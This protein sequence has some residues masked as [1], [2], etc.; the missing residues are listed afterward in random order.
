MR[1]LFLTISLLCCWS[2]C[3]VAQTKPD[4][5]EMLRQ[6]LSLPAP[7]PRTVAPG[8]NEASPE[9]AEKPSERPKPPADDAPI[10]V[11]R[12][13]WES[14]QGYPP[15]TIRPSATIKERLL[16]VFLDEPEKLVEL[17]PH[18]SPADAEKVKAAFDR[19]PNDEPNRDHRDEIR[20]WLVNHSKYYLNELLAQVNKVEDNPESGSV[21]RESAL[22]NLAEIDWSIA[23]PLLQTLADSSQQ[24]SATLALSML[25]KHAVESGN[26]STE[27]KFRARLQAIASD[28]G[29]PGRARNTAIEALSATK[30]SGR[31]D[32]YLSLLQDE[33][34]ITLHDGYSGFSPLN[35][36]FDADPDKWIPIMTKLVGGPNRTVQRTAASCLVRLVIQSPRRDAILP[37]LRWLSDP[38]W[39]PMGGTER[40]WFMQQM[41][42]L[43]IPESVP[44]LIWIIENEQFNA[45]WAART[46]AHYKDPRAI[47]ALKKA[48]LRS[49]EDD[50]NMILDGL[51]ASG[52]LTEAE[53]IDALEQYVAKLSTPEGRAEVEKNA[54]TSGSALPVPLSIG[55]YFASSRTVSPE[56]ARAVLTH[57]IRL[58]KQNP[59][60]SQALLRITQQWQSREVDLNIINRI[61][62]GTADAETIANALER[63]SKLR[64]S[65]GAELHVLLRAGGVAEAIGSIMLDD[66]ALAQ[67]ILSSGDQPAQIALLASAR[68][69]QT[70]LPVAVV[71]PLMKSRNALLA[72]AAER[73]LLAEDSEEAQTL[74]WQRHPGEAFVTGWREN[75]EFMS[76]NNFDAFEKKEEPLR[77]ELLKDNG[78]VEIFALLNNAMYFDRVLRVYSDRAVYTCYEDPSRYRERV[79]TKAELSAFKQFMQTNKLA[80]LGPQI[81]PCHHD[82]VV[83]ELLLLKKEGGR[84]VFSHRGF[85][86]WLSLLASLDGFG[87]GPGAKYRYALESEIKGLEV[88]YADDQ[89]RVTNVWQ[90]DDEIRVF[91]ERMRTV[92]DERK[93]NDFEP[94]GVD[95]D[96]TRELKRQHEAAYFKSLYAWRSFTAGK[97]TAVVDQPEVYESVD[98]NKF[99]LEI[100]DASLLHRQSSELRVL[101]SNSIIIARNFGGLWKQVAGNKPVRLSTE[102]AY[103]NPVV[104]PDG[105]WVV[106]AKTDSDWSAPNYVIRFNIETGR[107]FRVNLEPADEFGPMVFLPGLGK[108]LLRRMTDETHAEYYL[109]NPNTGETH[110][111]KGE[112]APLV[113]KGDRFLQATGKAEEFW[114]AIPDEAKD[115]T[116]V[117]RYNLKTFAFTPVLTI[118]HI[119]FESMAMWVDEVHNKVYVAYEVQLISIPLQRLV[120]TVVGN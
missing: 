114:A 79:I 69:T 96:T 64:E 16:E 32:W 84:R 41:D 7:T 85:N 27:D 18:L 2:T 73:Y 53:V 101:T 93:L 9:I 118:P 26:A 103:A 104:T 89:L 21:E 105:K 11:L 71:G 57:A 52:G 10:E 62:T 15:S 68:L 50:R 29:N 108:V 60:L 110:T 43:E 30:W 35:E 49:A 4:S 119:N 61:A 45:R 65:L 19:L 97:L 94:E 44:G 76:G 78:P 72:Q 14:Q 113:Q 38:D 77:N 6:L 47:P 24:R 115:Q 102:G 116:Q 95:E 56:I 34:L 117:G 83:S 82:C 66:S 28:R 87:N 99:P 33:T 63:H 80:E 36:I 17:L 13:Y 81:A 55:R 54:I 23:E 109:L 8:T 58:R 70:S 25:Y 98:N 75:L 1:H 111:V 100:E 106:L 51:L 107:E 48:L 67:T 59:E 120:A 3:V 40:A 37:V 22:T 112:F 20:K 90:H 86:G 5:S 92:D 91:T 12:K 42:E 46:V 88:L 39:I 74:L 31:D